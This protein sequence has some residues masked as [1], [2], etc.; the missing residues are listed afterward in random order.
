MEDGIVGEM[1]DAPRFPWYS[2]RFLEEINELT[3]K[4]ILRLFIMLML[5]MLTMVPNLILML[6][7]VL[8][9]MP[10]DSLVPP[11]TKLTASLCAV[12]LVRMRRERSPG[13]F[14][15]P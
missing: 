5:L 7:L 8:M 3:E 2:N 14:P 11:S 10:G 13:D 1:Y 15:L 6:M 9:L 12:A 4:L